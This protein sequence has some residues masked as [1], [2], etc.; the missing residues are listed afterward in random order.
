[1]HL[2]RPSRARLGA[3]TL[4]VDRHEGR[5]G[6]C[7]EQIADLRDTLERWQPDFNELQNIDLSCDVKEDIPL[8]KGDFNQLQQCIINLVF[9]SADAMPQGGKI[10]IVSSI[11]G[12][13]GKFGQANYSAAKA[14]MIGFTKALAQEGARAG[15]TVILVRDF[16]L[17]E[18]VARL[19]DIELRVVRVEA[20]C[21]ERAWSELAQWALG[22][23]GGKADRC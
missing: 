14:G 8:V 12:L 5:G 23:V 4:A 20:A 15:I 17:E 13:R 16:L 2:R 7:R 3:L 10:I 11:N 19:P 9:N 22:G 18:L 1:M 6:H 21:R